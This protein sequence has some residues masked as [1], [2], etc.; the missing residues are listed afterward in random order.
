MFYA[1]IMEPIIDPVP[2]ADLEA[3]LK[4]EYF[5]RNTNNA[6]NIIYTVKASE[7]P[8][9]MME[10]GRLRELA[11]R[12]AGGGTGM[13]VDI[14]EQDL[15]PDGYT[16][17]FVWD[18]TGRE[19]L[20][21]YRYIVSDSSDTSQLSTEH[22]FR[23]SDKF[24]KEI[25]PYTIELGRSFVQPRY[26]RTRDAKSLYALDNLWDGL[27]ALLVENPEKKYFFGKVTMYDKYNVEARDILMYFLHKYFPDN[28][29][30]LE[31]I[32]PVPMNIDT[33]RMD[34]MFDGESYKEDYKILV[35]ELRKRGEFVPPMINSYMSLSASMKVFDTVYNHDF[36]DVE[37][38]AIL[39]T[40]ADIYPQKKERHT[41]GLLARIR[42]E[43]RKGVE[44]SRA[45]GQGRL[46]RWG[47]KKDKQ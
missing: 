20:G 28:D 37:E 24:R 31:P 1:I 5:L 22:Y 23:F 17:L 3:E 25:L 38:T 2:R 43:Y 34:K 19:I 8:N 35:K 6:G 16:Q 45:Q 27:G 11:F 40:I 41:R 44:N 18:P 7:C 14:D 36:G 32:N 9:I 10:I 15:S 42:D 26:Q 4:P 29:H 47:N 39:I 12:Q 46:K 21:G 33:A 13:P 30:L